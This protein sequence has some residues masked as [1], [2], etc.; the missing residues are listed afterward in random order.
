M[1]DVSHP[2]NLANGTLELNTVYQSGNIAMQVQYHEFAASIEDEKTVARPAAR[3]PTPSARRAS[4]WIKNGGQAVN[5]CNCGI[6]GI[7]INGNASEDLKRAAYIFAIWSISKNTVQ[8][9]EGPRRHADPQVGAGDAGGAGARERPTTMPNALTFDA[10]YDVGIKN[11]N[12]VLGPEDPAG[13][14]VSLDPPGRGAEVPLRRADG[15][16]DLQVDPDAV[17]R[18]ERRLIRRIGSGAGPM[19]GHQRVQLGRDRLAIRAP[20]ASG[21]VGGSGR[22]S[23]REGARTIDYAPAQPQPDSPSRRLLLLAHGAG[24]HPARRHL[25]LSV[26]LDDLYEPA[27][28]RARRGADVWNNFENF[29]KLFTRDAKFIERLGA[30]VPVQRL[31]PVAADLLGV[32]LA[33]V[34]N[35]S[36]FEKFL[37]TALPDADDDG[38]DRRRPRLVLPLQRDLR[39]VSL[40][41][42]EPRHPGREVDPGRPTRRCTASSSSTSGSGRRSSR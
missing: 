17:R 20:A 32:F 31:V 3:P 12:F 28:R 39:L 11:P 9:A 5:G 37:V 38:A 36:R 35:G 2:D 13:Q 23:A 42:P 33:V 25:A 27:R 4:S 8:R 21:A 6:G 26:L 34:L 41:V 29:T 30:A 14:R 19:R 18:A 16:R 24:H 22:T 7:G 40:A 1:A 15:G 10:V